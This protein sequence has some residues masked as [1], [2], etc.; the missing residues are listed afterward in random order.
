MRYARVI[1]NCLILLSIAPAAWGAAELR[2]S[3]SSGEAGGTAQIPL[4][5][6]SD[7]A[8]TAF[9]VDITVP[10]GLLTI[11]RAE[12]AASLST[13]VAAAAPL[14]NGVYRVAIYSVF[15]DPL[16]SGVVVN[17]TTSVSASAPNGPVPV[18]LSNAILATPSASPLPNVQLAGGSFTVGLVQNIR[19]G[20]FK[21]STTNTFQFEITG[22]MSA[23]YVIESSA[24]LRQWTTVRTNP[25]SGGAA[26]FSGPIPQG[27]R[28]QF[29]RARV[30]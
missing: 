21:I 5:I 24:D 8:V 7:T 25:A 13:H 20:S 11:D 27:Q 6:Q 9:Q 23:S 22:L 10:F 1:W 18:T 15:N 3:A 28:V 17:L 14:S 19:L 12:P 29:Y 4:L 16:P 26:I 30:P 2:V